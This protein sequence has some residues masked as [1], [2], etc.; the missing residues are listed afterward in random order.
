MWLK[1][2]EE[3]EEPDLYEVLELQALTLN[4]EEFR[5]QMPS[6]WSWM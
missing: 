4:F 1:Q 6:F 3:A 2:V 5:G